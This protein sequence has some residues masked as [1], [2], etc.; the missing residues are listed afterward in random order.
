VH[1]KENIQL[2]ARLL[3]MVG[4]A[5]FRAELANGHLIVAH[6]GRGDKARVRERCK[7]GM[8]VPVILSPFDMSKGRIL[9]GE[10]ATS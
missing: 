10:E 2:D 7:I 3:N 4:D 5:A 8:T 1:K 9:L 6:A